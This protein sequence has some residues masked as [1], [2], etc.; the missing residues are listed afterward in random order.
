MEDP[1]I[2]QHLLEIE[3]RAAA[4]VDDAQAEADRRIKAGEEA[5][6]VRCEEQY[7]ALLASLEE[8]YRRESAAAR[9]EYEAI[10]EGWRQSLDRLPLDQ[11]A[12]AE[13][14]SSFLLGAE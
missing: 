9:T 5:R 13:L 1:G 2:L 7:Q 4:L 10:L 3:A 11:R 8:N 6:R 14:A 12:F